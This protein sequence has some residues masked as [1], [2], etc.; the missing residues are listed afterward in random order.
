MPQPQ[1]QQPPATPPT[2]TEPP[3]NK[4]WDVAFGLF[5]DDPQG[6]MGPFAATRTAENGVT[7]YWSATWYQVGIAKP[8][9]RY[10]ADQIVGA[11]TESRRIHFRLDGV[12]IADA[13]QTG[14]VGLG[15]SGCWTCEELYYIR[16][17]DLVGKT[18]FYLN[19]VKVATPREM[20]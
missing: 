6:V 15:N 7:C 12:R 10:L 3:E 5:E 4:P 14:S 8:R 1:P 11:M 2:N 20:L 13:L 17:N 19:N 18:D 16:A 9:Y